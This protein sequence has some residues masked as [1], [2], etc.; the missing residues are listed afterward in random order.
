MKQETIAGIVLCVIG[1]ILLI[2]PSS[3]WAITEKW[4]SSEAEGPSKAFM[5]IMRVLSTVFILIGTLLAA[6]LIQ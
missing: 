2:A 3:V 5:F 4:K 1:F 6:G